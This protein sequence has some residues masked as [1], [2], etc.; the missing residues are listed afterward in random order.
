[1]E[2]KVG[3]LGKKTDEIPD[4]F[5]AVGESKLAGGLIDPLELVGG[6]GKV[7]SGHEVILAN[8]VSLCQ[9]TQL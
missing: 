6:E 9:F 7:D 8:F 2:E 3:A 4:E 1:M 5:A